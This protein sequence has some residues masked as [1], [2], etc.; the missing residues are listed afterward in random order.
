V[1]RPGYE[2]TLAM[3]RDVARP[4]VGLCLD[5]PLFHERQSDDYVREAVRACGEHVM[6]THFGAWNFAEPQRGTVV[7]TPAPSVGGPI[8]YREFLA[9]LEQVGYNGYLVAEYCLPCVRDHRIA[10]ID[11]I[12]AAMVQSL[13]YMKS[14]MP[15]GQTV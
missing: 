3:L 11:D 2:D 14:V 6:L 8:N 5:V 15:V 4:N 12:D 9:G 1:L 10:G 13:A 7:Q